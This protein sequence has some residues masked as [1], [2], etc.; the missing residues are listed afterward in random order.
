[1]SDKTH[2]EYNESAVAL[3]ADM[4]PDMDFRCNGP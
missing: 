4:P 2:I 3:A 1:M